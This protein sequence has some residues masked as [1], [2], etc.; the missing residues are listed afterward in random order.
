MNQR[1]QRELALAQT[2]PA[3]PPAR[4]SDKTYPG[5]TVDTDYIPCEELGGDITGVF[6]I[7]ETRLG[8]YGGDVC[9]H[10]IYAAMVMSYVKKLI[11]TLG[12][13]DPPQGPVRREAARRGAHH[14]QPELH[15]RDQPGRSRD[16]P[17]AV[18][19]RPRPARSSTFEYSSAGIA[20]AA[21]RRLRRH[22]SRT[23]LHAVRLPHRPR[24]QPRVRDRAA[25]SSPRATRFLFVSDGVIEASRATVMFGMDAPEGGSGPHLSRTP[26]KLDCAERR[27][28]GPAL[29]RRPAAP[30][31]H[32][33]AF[34]PARR[35]G[36]TSRNDTGAMPARLPAHRGLHAG[37]G[38]PRRQGRPPGLGSL[39]ARLPR[40]DP[41]P[42][43]S[44]TCSCSR[45]C[46]TSRARSIACRGV[47]RPRG[48]GAAP[49]RARRD[50]CRRGAVA[51]GPPAPGTRRSALGLPDRGDR[52]AR[53]SP[54]LLRSRRARRSALCLPG[55]APAADDAVSDRG[56][57]PRVAPAP[58]ARGGRP[59]RLR[60]SSTTR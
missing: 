46:P 42:A 2:H 15:H 10:G 38:C 33:P 27:R 54:I 35:A 31:R 60:G 57:V 17:H 11:E 37:R 7:D 30:G 19:R 25:T 44:S 59:R 58:G 16:L 48:P 8:V 34:R 47:L 45:A 53:A 22:G 9:G 52:A 13:A 5:V 50:P 43:P 56:A 23:A 1:V 3:E 28:P 55:G 26:G 36:R 39:R 49:R 4:A 32:V 20:R 12:E 14:D 24:G 40:R 21:A 29:P 51:R 41:A 6:Q 18:P